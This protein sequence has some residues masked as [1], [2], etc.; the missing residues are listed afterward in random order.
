V[1][2]LTVLLFAATLFSAGH[3]ADDTDRWTRLATLFG[4]LGLM[5]LGAIVVLDV[6]RSATHDPLAVDL[7]WGGCNRLLE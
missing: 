7:L 4:L 6:V 3:S 5:T 2:L 1:V